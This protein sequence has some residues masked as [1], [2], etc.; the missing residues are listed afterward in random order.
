MP[1]ADIRLFLDDSFSKIKAT[2][3][4]RHLLPRAW[5]APAVVEEVVNK[6]SGQFIYASVVIKFISASDLHPAQQLD[7][8]RGL[9]P[10]GN[11]TPFAQLDALYRH[12]FSRVR[13][14]D[15]VFLILAWRIFTVKHFRMLRIE[16]GALLLGIE[17]SD[18]FIALAAL[19]SV[20]QCEDEEIHF[21]HA[22]L[23]DFLLDRARSQAYYLDISTW[24]SRLSILSFQCMSLNKGPLG[25]FIISDR[26]IF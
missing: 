25:V 13:D 5:P 22:S 18:V 9:R 19:N 6:S 20:V 8:I 10:S 7:I 17:K 21:L 3:H 16:R 1:D 24:T 15:L 2:H 11:L 26:V 12:I 23:P 4:F 14:I